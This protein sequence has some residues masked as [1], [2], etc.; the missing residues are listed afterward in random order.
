M[1]YSM[2]KPG[3]TMVYSTCSF[4]YEEDE[5]VI[6]YL[7]KQTDASLVKMPSSPLFYQSK[8]NGQGIHLFPFLFPG[9]GHYIAL[10]KKPGTILKKEK[11]TPVEYIAPPLP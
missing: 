11:K 2:L 1:A 9:E 4:S 3:G 8:N 6:D 5:E 10:I 7:L